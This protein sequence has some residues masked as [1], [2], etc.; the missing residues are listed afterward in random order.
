MRKMT[1]A[2]SAALSLFAAGCWPW[3]HGKS[4]QQEYAEALLHGNAM[5]ASQIWLNMSPED[6][7]KFSRGEGISPDPSQAEDTRRQILNHYESEMQ[8]EGTA[9]SAPMEQS[10]P[11]PL[12]QTLQSLPQTSGSYSPPPQDG[13]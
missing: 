12:G 11:T 2:L 3:G 4:P 7:L 6:R 13:N 5:A 1:I 9:A 8:G 10:I